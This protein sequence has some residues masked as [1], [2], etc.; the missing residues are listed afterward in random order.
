MKNEH[1][2]QNNTAAKRTYSA[3]LSFRFPSPLIVASRV[4]S[5]D[6]GQYVGGGGGV[7]TTAS[8]TGAV[9]SSEAAPGGKAALG[10]P[11]DPGFP[12]DGP[13]SIMTP[14]QETAATEY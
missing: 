4:V 7:S 12:L 1:P 3:A 13:R 8:R 14:W 2:T 6:E 11:P 10:H 9:L 5:R